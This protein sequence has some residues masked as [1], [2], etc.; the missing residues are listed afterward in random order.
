MPLSRRR[1][2]VYGLVTMLLVGGVMSIGLLAADIYVHRRT[3]DVAGVNIW[4]YRGAPIGDKRAGETRVVML[5]GSTVY[6]W[7]LPAQESIASFLERRLNA[8]GG[9][10]FS[11]VNLGAPGQGAYGFVTDL[12]DFAYL[13][14]DIVVLYEGYND[15][16]SITPRGQQ[17]YLLWRR[18]SP[19]FRWTGYY[20]ILPIVLREKADLMTSGGGANGE[21]RFSARIGAGAMRAV[22]AVTGDLAGQVGGLTPVPAN[23]PADGEC[24]ETWKRYCGSVRDAVAWVLARNKRV[25]FV[26]QPYVS[27]AHKEQQANAAAML[28]TR[29]GGDARVSYVN[30]GDAVDMRNR[31]IAYDGLHLIASG[32]D[33]IASRLVSPV[34]EAAQ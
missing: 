5:G 18:E 22:A 1:K 21:V 15:L 4:G 17:N 12:E 26:T 7:G 2:I 10:P 16:G 30:L 29:F 20:P 6:G 31:D 24:V 23:A 27:D 34:L 14:Y 13:D 8:S 9:R 32:N 25:I 3:Q 28:R 33:T 11:V 19:I